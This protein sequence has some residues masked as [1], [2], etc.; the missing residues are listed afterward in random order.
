MRIRTL[1]D[2][3]LQQRWDLSMLGFGGDRS[4]PPSAGT[5]SHGVGAFDDTGRLVAKMVARP[6]QQWWCGRPVPM[7]GIAGVVVHPD[8]R[9][10]G[11]VP[12]MTEVLLAHAPEPV[13]VLFPTAPGVYRRMGWEVVGSLDETVLPVLGLP[14]R[15][16]S[17]MLRGAVPADLDALREL[18]AARGR[19][20][21]G[22]LTRIGTSYTSTVL[23]RDVVTVA[24]QDGEVTGYVAYD[25]GTYDAHRIWV[26]DCLGSTPEALSALVGSLGSWSALVD[27]M[28]WR[29][30]TIDLQLLLG[31][32]VP[33]PSSV[34]PWMLRVLDPAAAILARGFGLDATAAFGLAGAGHQLVVREGR[35]VLEPRPADGL[36]TLTPQGLALLFAGVGRALH[37]SGHADRPVPELEAAFA[38]PPPE[39]LDYF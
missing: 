36:P 2:D 21:S 6:Y 5:P 17:V 33:A 1:T 39:M 22:L 8:G 10:Q 15:E 37:R 18:Y 12:R 38:G 35:G 7:A 26:R 14:A 13:S 24:E 29:G 25:R 27:T 11:L 28:A 20:G 32:R 23:D 4:S 30:S 9:G 34:Q 31:F 16:Q 19:T 3:D